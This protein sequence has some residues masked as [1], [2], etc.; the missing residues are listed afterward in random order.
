MELNCQQEPAE[1]DAEVTSQQAAQV[2]ASSVRRGTS[3]GG[4]CR[5]RRRDRSGGV[6]TKCWC[7]TEKSCGKRRLDLFLLLFLISYKKHHHTH[8][9]GAAE[10]ERSGAP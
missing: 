8:Q 3:A 5:V 6:L 2:E 4:V 1:E 7:Y 10:P 9:S